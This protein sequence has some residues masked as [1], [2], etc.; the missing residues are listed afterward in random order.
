M[1]LPNKNIKIALIGYRLGHGGAEKVMA[2][3]SQFFVK[4]GIEIHNI[5]VLDEVSYSYS[6]KLINLGK[7][8][9][10]SNGLL[11]KWRRLVFL[12]KHL[13]KSNFDFVLDF[14]FRIKPIQE[15]IIAK[16]I[17]KS[18][19]IFMVHSYLID[20]YMPNWSFITRL[21]YGDC[22]KVV[23][24][25]N[26]SKELIER[27]HQ[28]KNVVR[29]YNPIDIDDIVTKSNEVN[30]LPYDYIIGVGQME[31]NIKQFDKLIEAY[32]NSILPQVNI[33]LV[34]LGKGDRIV[35]L[36]KLANERNIEDKVH[37]LGYQD[38]PFKFLS[39][40]RYF[41]LSSLN[42]GL[43][44]VILESLAC[45][46]P[47]IAFNC[48]SGPSEMIQDKENGLLVENQNIEKLTEAMNLF[49]EDE[50]LY[51]YCKENAFES[52]QSFSVEN[53]GIQWLDLMKIS[54]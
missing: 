31:T 33:H 38:N 26:E 47:V 12:K 1:S 4:Q 37:F 27:K 18:K 35:K 36:Q 7:M 53:I 14:R 52:V 42:E 15:L 23:S 20:H 17:Y 51:R 40:A 54:L 45:E 22:Y 43:P 48:R 16:W 41:V 8:K 6:G 11:N 46:T 19:S 2:I 25:T 28:L 21:M 3:L 39:K 24:I 34:L 30:E 10:T 49:V 32:S 50:S 29:I 44:N 9:N 13:E 5:I